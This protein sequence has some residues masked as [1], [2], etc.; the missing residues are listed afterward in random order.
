MNSMSLTGYSRGKKKGIRNHVILVSS[1]GCVNAMVEQVCSQERDVIPVLHPNGCGHLHEEAE[2]VLK[3]LAGTCNN[4]NVGGVVVLGLGCESITSEQVAAKVDSGPEFNRYVE[5]FDLQKIKE[6][7]VP[8][9]RGKVRA[10]KEKVEKIPCVPINWSDITI[11]LE[12]G[13]SDI[14]SGISA[15]PATGLVSDYLVSQGGRVILSEVPEMIGAEEALCQRVKDAE[16]RKVIYQK[17]QRYIDLAKKHGQDLIGSNPTPG[18]IKSGITTI[19]E[20]SLGCILKGGSSEIIDF[21]DY[22]DKPSQTSGLF[23]MDTP[24]ND[25]E[26]LTG[27]AAG[28]AQVA[29]FTTGRGTPAGHP[30]MPVIKISSNSRVMK[31]MAWAIDV[32][33]GKVLEGSS[34][35]S[36]AKDIITALTQTCSLIPTKAERNRC[37]NFAIS[38]LSPLT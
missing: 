35:D 24:G 18:N 13:G 38:R 10:I 20:K 17:T 34:L 31:N 2:L 21:L 14:F 4:P 26:S 37:Y 6:D 27:M 9:I 29:L 5:F 3:T 11:G 22:A 28:G 1:V 7:V 16:L 12:C 32:D 19:E 30:I 23:L 25:V 36:A 33:A 15:N 8:F